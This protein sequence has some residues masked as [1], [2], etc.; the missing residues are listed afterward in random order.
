MIVF[1]ILG[2]LLAF[3]LLALVV[4]V[5]FVETLGIISARLKLSSDIAG[6]TFMAVGSSAPELFVSLLAL[7]L[8]RSSRVQLTFVPFGP[9]KT[10]KSIGSMYSYS[11]Y[12][13]SSSAFVVTTR[14]TR[15]MKMMSGKPKTNGRLGTVKKWKTRMLTT[16]VHVLHALL[17]SAN[18]RRNRL[19]L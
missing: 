11:P 17:K 3:Y 5:Y 16:A 6:A 18:Q 8:T 13:Y 1:W 7:F 10:R 14:K 4:E 12:S 15:R 9:S 19:H 2:L